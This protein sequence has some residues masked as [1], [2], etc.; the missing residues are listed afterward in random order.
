MGVADAVACTAARTRVVGAV[1]AIGRPSIVSKCSGHPISARDSAPRL[2]EQIEV[3]EYLVGVG[4]DINHEDRDGCS[5]LHF[6]A[7]DGSVDMIKFMVE[8]GAAVNKTCR[9]SE[10]PL[11]WASYGD[12]TTVMDYLV[13]VGGTK[14]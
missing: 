1:A 2:Q 10:T 6:L 12:N 8:N 13:S 9:G 11:K 7:Q 4:V 14:M 3:V 5:A